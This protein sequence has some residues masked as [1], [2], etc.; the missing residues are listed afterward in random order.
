MD[1]P[2]T[3]LALCPRNCLQ[4]ETTVWNGRRL[5]DE[6]ISY[7]LSEACKPSPAP[8][9]EVYGAVGYLV[10]SREHRKNLLPNADVC[11]RSVSRYPR[12]KQRLRRSTK[13]KKRKNNL[14][15]ASSLIWSS[16]NNPSLRPTRHPGHDAARARGLVVVFVA[17]LEPFSWQ[18]A[19]SGWGLLWRQPPWCESFPPPRPALPG[20]V[21]ILVDFESNRFVG[22]IG[23]AEFKNSEADFMFH[24]NREYSRTLSTPSSRC[25]PNPES[26]KTQTQAKQFTWSIYSQLAVG[27]KH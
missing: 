18:G 9:Y 5:P 2:A 23:K 19:L 14:V 3:K 15:N 24:A 27:S 13:K 4:R 1:W 16:L 8:S 20:P 12:A 11:S 10:T 21:L 22:L 6:L 26:R 17:G 25:V 7:T